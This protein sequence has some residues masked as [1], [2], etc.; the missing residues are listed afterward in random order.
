MRNYNMAIINYCHVIIALGAQYKNNHTVSATVGQSLTVS[1]TIQC[2]SDIE[3]LSDCS[4]NIVQ[5]WVIIDPTTDKVYFVNSNNDRMDF[6][7]R[8]GIMDT[9]LEFSALQLNFEQ[10]SV[11]RT[12]EFGFNLILHNFTSSMEGLM[13]ICGLKR[14]SMDGPTS[15][16][17]LI[18]SY[19]RLRQ[20][21]TGE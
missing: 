4:N 12:V 19:A 7:P 9:D 16:S 17:Y 3:N 15:E 20:I 2:P 18:K 8:F 13:V 10:C 14:L 1:C 6:F 21:Q 5:D 11:N